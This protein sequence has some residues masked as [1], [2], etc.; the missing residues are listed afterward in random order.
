M[1]SGNSGDVSL[2]FAA[3]KESITPAT[4]RQL[5]DGFYGRARQ[6]S[7]LGPVFDAHIQDQWDQHLQKMYQF[8]ETVLLGLPHYKGAPLLVHQG[9]PEITAAHFGRWLELFIATAG[10]VF[11]GRDA[12]F[13]A[14][15][16]RIMAGGLSRMVLAN[17]Q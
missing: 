13:V 1:E 14:D 2:P 6:D 10:D 9:L 8:W 5:V 17:R 4:I 7:L 3:S 11:D 12:A 15:R 16:V